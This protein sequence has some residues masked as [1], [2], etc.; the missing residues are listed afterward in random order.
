M[1]KEWARLPTSVRGSDAGA[2][3]SRSPAA[4]A[5]AV[6]S[7]TP[8]GR[9]LRRTRIRP[10]MP[11]TSRT[12]TPIASSMRI[13]RLTVASMPLMSWATDTEPEPSAR[14]ALTTRHRVL[15]DSESTT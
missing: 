10:V 9:R 13:S 2:R 3:R 11:S 8:S 7:T 12:R 6:S 4:I 1:L 15:P 5:A 14:G